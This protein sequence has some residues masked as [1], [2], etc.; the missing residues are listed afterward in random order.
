M[1]MGLLSLP[2][3]LLLVLSS[4]DSAVVATVGRFSITGRDLLDS[5]EVGPAFVKRYS[6]PLRKHLEYMIYEQLLALEAGR[7]GYD[8]SA[9]VRNRVAA[10]E[11]DLTV[12]EL[13]KDDIL[14]E[15]KLT[16]KEIE[17]GIRKERMNLQL[18][19]LY[20]ANGEEAQSLEAELKKGISFDSL[21]AVNC[22]KGD[23]SSDRSLETTL[24]KL[25]RDTP[26]LARSI[27]NLKTAQASAPIEGPDGYYLVRL[28][29]VWQ[30][31]IMTEA[32][33][34]R[35]RDG[36]VKILMSSR[37][38][39]LAADYV[40]TKME[41]ANPV[42][43]AEGLNIVRAYVADKGL[44]RDTRV[45]WDIPST[46][47]TEAGPQP[48]STSGK[49]LSRPLVVFGNNMITVRD[50]VVWFDIRQFQLKTYSIEA[51]NSSVKRTIWKMVQ[52]KL[53]S[54]EAYAR[55][56][57]YQDEVKR[58]TGKWGTKLLYLA[59]RSH[60]LRTVRISEDSLKREYDRTKEL[61]RD[62]SGKLLSFAQARDQMWTTKYYAEEERVLSQTLRRLK[63]VY[64]VHV[65]DAVVSRLAAGIKRESNPVNVIFYK[66]GGTFPRVAFPTIDES[67][68]RLP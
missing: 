46:F 30:N 12:D 4:L 5:Y 20:A 42:I 44:S 66:P 62:T 37:A 3:W 56:L 7:L 67:W 57:N 40:R 43:R 11:E 8:T 16:D 38:D 15:V 52:D 29:H 19:W 21:Y 45:K 10:L 14:A 36:A 35:L 65:D 39:Q 13:Y 54:Q 61:Y 49:F 9:F 32:E 55:S 53:L 41:V 68:Q 25:E 26:E 23:S 2:C 58:E 24:L 47:M 63:E 18:R 64:P 6:N 51:F 22:G 60:I 48:I 28:D 1:T 33:Y 17:E 31:P 34:G 50:Y 27:A 59:G